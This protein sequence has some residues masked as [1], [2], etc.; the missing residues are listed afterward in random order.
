[1]GEKINRLQRKFLWG[2]GRQEENNGV[3]WE[4]ICVSKERGL[5]I[6]DIFAFSNSLLAK[7]RWGPLEGKGELW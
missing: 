4:K 3:K 5:G 7:W 6:K 1:M 2:I